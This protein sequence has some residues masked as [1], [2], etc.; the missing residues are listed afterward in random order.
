MNAS[1]PMRTFLTVV[2]VVVATISVAT[3]AQASDA[4]CAPNIGKRIPVILVHGL[5][6]SPT[7]WGSED[8]LSSMVHAL[9]ELSGIYVDLPAF[10]YS[11]INKGWVDN[12]AIGPKLAQRIACLALSSRQAGGLGK[13]VIVAHSMGGLAARYAGA[14]T[15]NGRKVAED[16]GLVVTIGTPNLGSGWANLF[17][18][19]LSSLCHP[20]TDKENQVTVS[21]GTVCAYLDALNGLQDRSQE[22]EELPKL[23]SDVPVLAIAGDVTLT[24]PLFH[25][26]LKDVKSD[27]IVS[28]KSALQGQAHQDE[29]GGQMV[30]TCSA[31]V[32]TFWHAN[33]WHSALPHNQ[34]VEQATVNAIK[35]Y[36]A[37]I[38]FAPTAVFDSYIGAWHVHGYDLTIKSDR[39]G[40]DIWHDGFSPSG[41]W[42]NGND[43]ITFTVM[44]DGSLVGTVENSWYTPANDG[45]SSGDWQPGDRFTL[46]HQG[47]HLLYQTWEPPVPDANYLCDTYAAGQ[48]WGQCGA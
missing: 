19:I 1:R 4:G 3:P 31:A 2:I 27:V 6:S 33:C 36:L 28:E 23:P 18:V 25:I 22:I 48:G 15:V 14:Q 44:P 34:T 8:N 16:M 17:G 26:Q 10:D 32:T 24:V 47:N 39:T 46:V 11:Q 29:G 9:N 5:A 35:K 41:D 43:S 40:Q 45:C 37:S 12:P 42:C 21:N 30:V 13:V 38:E 7:V 20:V